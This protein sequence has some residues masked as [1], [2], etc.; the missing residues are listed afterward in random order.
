MTVR[1]FAKRPLVCAGVLSLFSF[2][3]ILIPLVP[4][5]VR[6]QSSDLPGKIRGYKLHRAAI[7]IFTSTAASMADADAGVKFGEPKL[8]DASL[9]GITIEMPIETRPMT[10][11]GTIDFLT[12]EDFRVNGI[13]VEIEEFKGPIV[14]KKGV[15]FSLP[16]PAKIFISSG[17]V[18]ETAWSEFKNSQDRWLVTG[19]VLVFGEF[20]R[21][22]HSFKRVIPV[23]V[24]ISIKNLLARK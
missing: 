5:A 20:R 16:K 18:L 3:L 6:A 13:P 23:D 21:M 22:G 9:S 11:A 8:I 15:T 1:S 17:S 10:S 24:S 2:S 4:P 7:H 14:F 19:R 12:F